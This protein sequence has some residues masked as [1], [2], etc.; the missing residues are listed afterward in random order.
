M[1]SIKKLILHTAKVEK[2]FDEIAEGEIIWHKM[3]GEF[4]KP[5]HHDVEE[6]MENSEKA[7]GQRI[8]GEDPKSGK[9]ILVRIG[10][11]GPM[12]QLGK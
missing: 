1:F 11:F 8:L 3:L 4:Y 2:Q 5:F 7:T 6:T 10:R 9:P 12:V